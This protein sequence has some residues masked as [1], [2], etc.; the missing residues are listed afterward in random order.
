MATGLQDAGVC[1]AEL[2]KALVNMVLDA[3]VSDTTKMKDHK[4]A[5]KI[6]W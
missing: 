2:V 5:G 4:K 3:Q 6:K 1:Q